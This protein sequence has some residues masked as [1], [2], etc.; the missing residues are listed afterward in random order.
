[1]NER[2]MVMLCAPER[3]RWPASERSGATIKV[4]AK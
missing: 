2:L 3:G 4:T 1:M